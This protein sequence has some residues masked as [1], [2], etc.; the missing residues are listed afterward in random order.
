MTTHNNGRVA[1][2]HGVHGGDPR[3]SRSALTSDG[4]TRV[5]RRCGPPGAIRGPAAPSGSVFEATA[6]VAGFENVAVMGQPVEQRR[7]HLGVAEHGITPQYR[8]DCHP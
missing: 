1:V 8:N 4:A 2:V 3:V 5:G 6:L 7:G